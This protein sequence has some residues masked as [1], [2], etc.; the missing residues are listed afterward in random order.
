MHALV[1]HL[2]YSFSLCSL[3]VKET[4]VKI[5]NAFIPSH[6]DSNLQSQTSSIYSQSLWA[7]EWQLFIPQHWSE[8]PGVIFSHRQI[9]DLVLFLLQILSF[10]EAPE[11]FTLSQ[12]CIARFVKKFTPSTATYLIYFQ[13]LRATLVKGQ[14]NVKKCADKLK[15]AFWFLQFLTLFY[16]YSVI[17]IQSVHM[18]LKAQ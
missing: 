2:Y 12:Q 17:Q 9:T 3:T 18:T 16:M 11:G 6:Q 14:P 8:Q 15:R 13:Y 7:S 5:F 1:K 4:V 10:Q